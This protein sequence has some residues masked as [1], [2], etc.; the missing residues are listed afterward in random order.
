MQSPG[1]PWL[2][3]L[4]CAAAGTAAAQTA[5]PPD[6]PSED[7]Q[8]QREWIMPPLR[9]T[10][11][12][13][14]DARVTRTSG[15]PGAWTQLVTASVGTST[16]IYQ[17][18][19]ATVGGNLGLSSSWANSGAG[20]G[21]DET[22]GAEVHNRMRS[23]DQFV[24]GAL[25][26]DLVPRSRFPAEIQYERQDS[27]SDSAL[28]SSIDFRRQTFGMTQRYRPAN[29]AYDLMGN[30]EHRTEEGTGFRNRQNSLQG[31]FGKQWKSH[32]VQLAAAH[33][34]A[35]AEAA[36]DETRFTSL[37]AR[38]SYVP[39]SELSINSSA[40]VTRTEEFAGDFGSDL[41]VLQLASV[42]LYHKEG[43]P[44]T[45]TGSLRGVA[46]REGESGGD[47]VTSMGATLGGN[48]EVNRN[49][50]LS[51]SAGMG[52]NNSTIGRSSTFNGTFGLSYQGDTLTFREI[53]YGWFAGATAS[54]GL[55]NTD[56]DRIR[57]HSMGLQVGHNASRQWTL[58]PA[59]SMTVNAAQTLSGT[60]SRSS[61][62]DQLESGRRSDRQLLNT[63]AATLQNQVDNRTASAR[64]SFSDSLQLGGDGGRFQ[65]FDV[66]LSGTY[67]FG[68]GR[69]IAGDLSYQRT[70]Q[71][72]G[73]GLE[74]EL[75]GGGSHGISGDISF[76][77]LQLFGVRRL[78]FTSRLRLA[79]DVLDQPGQLVSIPDRE[80][81]VWENRLD[82]SIGRLD[83]SLVLRMSQVDRFRSNSLWLR[84]S[85]SFSN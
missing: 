14:Y 69:T 75:A 5:A 55:A 70:V 80:T 48:Y 7:P 81:R 63:V 45:L 33:S 30:F 37:V 50:R 41:Q 60:F 13:G 84:V 17:P 21:I 76:R 11:R 79:Q 47:T 18:W 39:S 57:Q 67:D 72:G 73:S 10:G 9:W 85:R 6:S 19:L 44:Y 15:E 59:T 8:P 66:Q 24:T 38:H 12:L 1:W 42:G 36:N 46:L 35:T 53:N 49:L 52:L 4:A 34:R 82:W 62:D 29:N 40:N 32:D 43:S 54:T 78:S 77:Q 23:R 71:R 26:L 65:L 68:Q 64:A 31:T 3:L 61:D 27:R 2:T 20:R 16:Y 83:T 51:A 74:G 25:R 22:T 28:L 58:S 56:T